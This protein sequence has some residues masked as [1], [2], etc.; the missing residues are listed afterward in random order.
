MDTEAEAAT[1]ALTTIVV[2]Q[3]QCDHFGHM[4]VRHYAA[5]FD[6][7]IFVF[8][9]RCGISG[10]QAIVPV[11]AEIKLSFR[12]EVVA[13]TIA[14]IR[15]RVS[16]V[17]TKSV[18]LQMEMVDARTQDL[19]ATCETVEVFFNLDSRESHPIPAEIR[20]RLT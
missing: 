1:Q 14:N 11:S 20:A 18:K 12:S 13:G 4:N 5:I 15:S 8:W 10:K 16:H 3:W 7:A 6:D 17:G 19:F 2:H 9:G